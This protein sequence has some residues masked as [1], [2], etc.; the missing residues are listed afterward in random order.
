MSD[1]KISINTTLSIQWQCQNVFQEAEQI[2]LNNASVIQLLDVFETHQHSTP[3]VNK[4]GQSKQSDLLRLESK[5][6]LLLLLFTRNQHKQLHRKIPHYDVKLS[7]DTLEITTTERLALNQL[8][9]LEIFF[10]VNCPEPL[11]FT[12]K[13]IA[14]ETTD[15]LAI[16]FI[17]LEQF[18]QTYLEKYIFRFHRNEIA[19]IKQN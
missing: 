14:T 6:D 19:R 9:E 10:E 13:V 3:I 15:V 12:G 16:R 7:A 8:I 1:Q 2:D 11:L 5:I 4:S 18:T 17:N